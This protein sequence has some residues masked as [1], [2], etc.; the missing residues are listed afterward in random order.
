MQRRE[1]GRDLRVLFPDDDRVLEVTV[2]S[3]DSAAV[4]DALV[5]AI[6]TDDPDQ[7]ERVLRSGTPAD[8]QVK[9]IR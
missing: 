2:G 5:E 9:R 8:T 1:P 6:G 7:A 4:A 3:E